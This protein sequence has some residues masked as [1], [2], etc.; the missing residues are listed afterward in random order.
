MNGRVAAENLPARMLYAGGVA[1]LGLALGLSAATI[2]PLFWLG[3]VGVAGLFVTMVRPDLVVILLALAI[4]L[5]VEIP[6]RTIETGFT[7][8]E[9]LY[10]KT[11][12]S[13][14]P[15][16]FLLGLLT[17]ALLVRAA[18]DPDL[19]RRLRTPLSRPLLVFWLAAGLSL[20]VQRNTLPPFAFLI[21]ALYW[22]RL[23]EVFTV[24]YIVVAVIR[25]RVSWERCFRAAFVGAMLSALIALAINVAYPI[26][27]EGW[28]PPINLAMKYSGEGGNF[29]ILWMAVAL[30]LLEAGG[31]HSNR[32]LYLALAGLAG[33]GT[34]LLGKR[35]LLL[36]LLVALLLVGLLTRRVFRLGL[37]LPMLLLLAPLSILALP[38]RLEERLATTF[39][40][41]LATWHTLRDEARE[42]GV[43][44]D[45]V[46]ALDAVPIDPSSRHRMIRWVMAVAAFFKQPILGVGFWASPWAGIGLTHNQYLQV[47]AE[48]GLVGFATLGWMMLAMART[49]RQTAVQA[50]GPQGTGLRWGLIA[51]AVSLVVQGFAGS[52]LLYFNFM[53]AFLYMVALLVAGGRLA[54]EGVAR[55]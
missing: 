23:G 48:M 36:G 37:L 33:L 17:I 46:D 9:T 40:S 5:G 13:L 50:L 30:G 47:L 32:P 49:L 15:A 14:S 26:R 38:E 51:S 28:A 25:D 39:T 42:Q 31:P 53:L 1:V 3:V 54:N 22:L 41:D 29:S 34:L 55:T 19:R 4:P 18:F 2:P 35:L 24:Y 6:I 8:A 52:P 16:D 44:L 12:V 11:A 43:P 20:L 45:L 10:T 7:I 27:G 21:C